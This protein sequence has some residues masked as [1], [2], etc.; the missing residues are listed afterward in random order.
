MLRYRY[1]QN[2]PGQLHREVVE[3]SCLKRR[4]F[5]GTDLNTSY[6]TDREYGARPTISE[7][8]DA[9]VWGALHALIEMRIGNGAFGFRFAEQ[10]PDGNGPCGCDRQAFAQFLEAEVPWINWPLLIC[11]L[12]GGPGSV[13]DFGLKEDWDGEESQAGRD[14]RQVAR[15]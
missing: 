2:H 4:S 6:Y 14:H 9:R 7:T 10:C 11:P 8:V 5:R 12:L 15:G 1:S 3:N 13:L